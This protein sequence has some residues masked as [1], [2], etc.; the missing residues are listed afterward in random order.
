MNKPKN[1][2]A[3]SRSVLKNRSWRWIHFPNITEKICFQYYMIHRL[4]ESYS[5]EESCNFLYYRKTN[6]L[7]MQKIILE[8]G[9][10]G[11]SI[12]IIRISMIMENWDDTRLI[13]D[14]ELDYFGTLT[15]RQN[16]YAFFYEENVDGRVSKSLRSSVWSVAKYTKSDQRFRS[17]EENDRVLLMNDSVYTLVLSFFLPSSLWFFLRSEIFSSCWKR[18]L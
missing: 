8:T 1:V 2:S 11:F 12:K 6:W 17:F 4:S 18:R 13:V 15:L 9:I 14:H 10:A 5:Y 3:K 7:C 16:H